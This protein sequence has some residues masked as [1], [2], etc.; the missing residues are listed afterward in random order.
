MPTQSEQAI[1]LIHTYFTGERSE[2]MALLAFCGLLLAAG[3]ALICRGDLYMRGLAVALLL[4]AALFTSACI[5]LLIRDKATAERLTASPHNEALVI[6]RD[7]IAKVVSNYPLYRYAYLAVAVLALI[8]LMLRPS[9]VLAG[10]G[11]GLLILVCT[12]FVV[13]HYSERR[14]TLYAAGLGRMVE[15]S[16]SGGTLS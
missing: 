4:A 6:E 10:L 15:I 11:S 7:R 3:L 5:P 12:G 1:I 14:A 16:T 2:Q 9:D 13:D 8:A